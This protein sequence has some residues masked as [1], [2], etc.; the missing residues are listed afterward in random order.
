MTWVAPHSFV[1]SII[2]FNDVSF[3]S[4]V[5]CLIP[6]WLSRS[7][8]FLYLFGVLTLLSIFDAAT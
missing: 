8:A 7:F 1:R 6:V 2:G 3:S 5:S 4:P